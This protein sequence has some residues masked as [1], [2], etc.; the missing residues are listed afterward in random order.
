MDWVSCG[1]NSAGPAVLV[2]ADTMKVL[3]AM[4][5]I[6]LLRMILPVGSV[7]VTEYLKMTVAP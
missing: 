2:V 3:I 6:E 5:G 7:P 4:M 1:V